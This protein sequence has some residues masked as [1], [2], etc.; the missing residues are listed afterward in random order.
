MKCYK[1]LATLR[2]MKGQPFLKGGKEAIVLNNSELILRLV[3]QL[4]AEK[5]KNFIL[6]QAQQQQLMQDDSKA[7]TKE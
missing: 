5:E 1:I 3:E 4:V 2:S 6:Q 7:K